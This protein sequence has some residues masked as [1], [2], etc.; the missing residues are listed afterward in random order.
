MELARIIDELRH[1]EPALR[2]RGVLH[3]AVF[4]SRARG[5]NRPNS[6]TDIMIDL[7]PNVPIGVWDYAGLKTYIASLVEGPVDVDDRESLKPAI[8]PAAATDAVYA[9]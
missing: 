4:G 7:D 9:F 6:D 5:D 2:A 8:R 1:H 3:L